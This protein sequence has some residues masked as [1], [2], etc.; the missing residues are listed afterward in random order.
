M[1]TGNTGQIDFSHW[2]FRL[3]AYV[4]DSIIIGIVAG[5]IVFGVFAA[6]LFTGGLFLFAGFGLYFLLFP[7]ILGILEVLYFAILDV[8]W[9]ATIGKRVLGFQVQTVSGGKVDFGKAFIRNI[10]KIYWLLLLLDWIIGVATPGDK[11]QKY[12]DRIAGTVVVQVRQ[13]FQSASPPPPPPPT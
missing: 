12:T 4:I 3:I 7:L 2:I 8:S 11:R 9:G 13:A 1:T 5:I 10:S 6:F